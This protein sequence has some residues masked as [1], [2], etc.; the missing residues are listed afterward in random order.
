MLSRHFFIA[1]LLLA[2]PALTPARAESIPVAENL[3]QTAAE[4][5]PDKVYLIMFG[6]EHCPYCFEMRD[7]Y[8]EPMLTDPD[9]T[10]K[11]V[12]REVEIDQ[13]SPMVDFDGNKTLQ[14]VYA[15]RFGVFLTP[16]LVFLD[17]KGREM[18]KKIVGLGDEN[19]FTYY[20]DEAI[21]KALEKIRKQSARSACGFV[22]ATGCRPTDRAPARAWRGF[23]V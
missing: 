7:L 6:A 16:T 5:G 20:L 13:N 15:R 18:A 21:G 11:L 23:A 17:S 2:L 10:D 19:Y 4:N 12:I 8:L 14:S 22:S 3:Q 1:V 9:Y